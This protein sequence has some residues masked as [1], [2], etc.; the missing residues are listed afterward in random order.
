MYAFLALYCHTMSFL[1][2]HISGIMADVQRARS[3]SPPRPAYQAPPRPAMRGGFSG[4]GR[5]ADVITF[6]L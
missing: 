5:Y 3:R 2:L 4:G 1:R 6:K